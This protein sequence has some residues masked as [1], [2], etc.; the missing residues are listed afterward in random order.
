MNMNIQITK[1]EITNFRNIKNQT[2]VFDGNSRIVGKNRIGKTNTLEAIYYLLTD[3]LLDGSSDI[4]SI[5]PI[6]LSGNYDKPI[7]VEIAATFKKESGETIMLSK[8]FIENWVKTR[9]TTETTLKGHITEYAINGIV[10]NTLR[11]YQTELAE[12]LNVP[13]LVNGKIDYL[14][15]LT[16][17]FFLGNMSESL[18]W[19]ELRNFIIVMIG[20]VKDEDV[21]AKDSNLS[22]IKELVLKHGGKI[23]YAKKEVKS[24]ID[25]FNNDLTAKR[26]Q[27]DYISKIESVSN[28]DLAVAK[29]KI[30][31]INNQIYSLTYAK[32]DDPI[33]KEI[34]TKI[35][36][37]NKEIVAQKEKEIKEYNALCSTDNNDSAS[38]ELN[39]QIGEKITHK[40]SVV[41]VIDTL[42]DK[43]ETL[44]YEINSNL[45]ERGYLIE[46]LNNLSNQKLDVQSECPTCH[47]PFEQ[48]KIDEQMESIKK[49]LE[50]QKVALLEKGKILKLQREELMEKVK[51]IE[52][53]IS[54]KTHEKEVLDSDIEVLKDQL[55]KVQ[56]N[57]VEHKAFAFSSAISN[58]ELK[59][60]GLN[61]ELAHSKEDFAKG[62]SK[63]YEQITLLK[64][65]LPPFNSIVEKDNHYQQSLK[66]LD[67]IKK[68]IEKLSSQLSFAE[69]K[70]MA[71]VQFM[72]TKLSMLDENVSKVF[73][74]LKFQ[75]IRENLKA[76]SFDE[77]C[78]PLIYDLKNDISTEIQFVCGSKSEKVMTGILMAE[79]IKKRLNLPDLPYLFDEG[80][81]IDAETMKNLLPTKAQVICVKVVDDVSIPTVAKI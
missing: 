22:I 5:K 77:I 26:S 41:S 62:N 73:G 65:Q 7:K 67:L 20:D 42:K 19:K 29:S 17:P 31:E 63:I 34:E 69:Q 60:K 72:R 18:D 78:K 57:K 35:N 40:F 58:L 56:L 8:K 27:I 59:L 23:D 79:M 51:L 74:K 33:S 4:A 14:K 68:D 21:F 3:T 16:N 37:L 24:E 70:D 6:T 30:E 46:Q 10:K 13:V 39:F 28:E 64:E 43:A 48:S 80:G 53:E 2:F 11:E 76:G 55:N 36:S 66:D 54:D 61:E 50:N 25:S 32:K 12:I 44:K 75:L 52:T 38:K 15:L 81:E 49:S 9:G 1:L 45:K 71:L 47:R